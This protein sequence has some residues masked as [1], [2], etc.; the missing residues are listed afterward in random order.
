MS[1]SASLAQTRV[2][3]SAHRNTAATQA[4][5]VIL[6]PRVTIWKD[7]GFSRR[8]SE[9]ASEAVQVGLH[10]VLAQTFERKGYKLRFDPR[11]MAQ[12]EETPP[13]DGPVQALKD[14]FDSLFPSF[15]FPGCNLLLKTSLQSDLKKVTDSDEFDVVVL[16]RAHA[17]VLTK[18]A[19]VIGAIST[20]WMTGPDDLLYFGIGV[21]DG[22]TGVLLYYCESTASGDYVSAPDSRLSVPVQKCL[23]QYFSG[24]PKHR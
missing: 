21:V 7:K 1:S 23:K 3:S 2:C 13:N 4:R 19:K 5:V 24:G 17:E 16:A 11:L 22:S 9:G 6:R 12:W 14:H 15:R 10:E 20:I 18:S 8:E